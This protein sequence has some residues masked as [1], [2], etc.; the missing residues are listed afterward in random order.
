MRKYR[1]RNY[2][3]VS[4][5]VYPW[6]PVDTYAEGF[7]VGYVL[8]GLGSGQVQ[9][10]VEGTHDDVVTGAS[11]KAF[12]LVTAVASASAGPTTNYGTITHPCAALRF[13]VVAVSGSANLT[14]SLMQAGPSLG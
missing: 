8:Q 13:R 9:G 11:A 7:S 1:D 5:G 10:N 14:F 2:I 3:A 6:I 12:T 4:A